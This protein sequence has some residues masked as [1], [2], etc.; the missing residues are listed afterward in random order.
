LKRLT[1]F[2]RRK[3][4]SGVFFREKENA[5]QGVKPFS[6]VSGREKCYTFISF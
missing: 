4:L 1:V 2:F 3:A 6:V 5:R